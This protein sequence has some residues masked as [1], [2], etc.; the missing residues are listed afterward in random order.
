[1]TVDCER[2]VVFGKAGGEE[3]GKWVRRSATTPPLNIPS[4]H[5]WGLLVVKARS[6]ISGVMIITCWKTYNYEDGDTVASD[7][8]F[9][10][11]GLRLICLSVSALLLPPL[12]ELQMPSSQA[13]HQTLLVPTAI[14]GEAESSVQSGSESDRAAWCPEAGQQGYWDI[15]PLQLILSSGCGGRSL[16]DP[17][18]YIHT[19][20]QSPLAIQSARPQYQTKCAGF[21]P[22]GIATGDC[23]YICTYVDLRDDGDVDRSLPRSLG[24]HRAIYLAHTIDN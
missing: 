20:L 24:T 11:L 17:W 9:E 15:W 23:M 21:W 13:D 5:V 1:M 18:L 22:S 7:Q 12:E 2:W 6:L 4:I 16:F 10:F 3:N 19:Y 14:W 8:C